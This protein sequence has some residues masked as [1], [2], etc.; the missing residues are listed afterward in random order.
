MKRLIKTL[1]LILGVVLLLQCSALNACAVVRP[2]VKLTYS[3]EQSPAPTEPEKPAEPVPAETKATEPKETE[4]PAEE[5]EAEDV[6]CR[7]NGI[8][9]INVV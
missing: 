3:Y 9:H 1:C 4:A 5:T 2:Q 8:Q 7:R 6:D